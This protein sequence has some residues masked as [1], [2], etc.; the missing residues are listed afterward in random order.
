L[1]AAMIR[2]LSSILFILVSGCA[3]HHFI[4]RQSDVVTV[5]LDAPKA[6]EVIFVSSADSFQK[7]ETQKNSR[8]VWAIGNLAD[9]E[10]Y[11]FYIVDG[12]VYV[13]DCR[14]REIDDFGGTHCIYQP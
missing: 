10:F 9:R 8:G 3:P 2:F 1:E 5:Y 4:D 14:Y 13:P 12:R 6:S 7:H 11:Y